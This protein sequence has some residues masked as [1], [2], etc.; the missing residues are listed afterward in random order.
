M[1]DITRRPDPRRLHL[2]VHEAAHAVVGV[3]HGARLL[4]ATLASDGNAGH[5]QFTAASFTNGGPQVYRSH[6]AA[7]GAV[8]EAMLTHG[9]R[10]TLRQIEARLCGSDKED[11]H[12]QAMATLLPVP[13]PA[14]EVTSLLA[15]CW[16]AVADLAADLYLGTAITHAQVCAGLGLTD[17]GGPGSTQLATIRNGWAPPSLR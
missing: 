5:T 6:I 4:R 7:A 15:R 14:A 1:T 3:I 9:P 16:P 12:R 17:E 11:L 8:A 10:P 13:V 2:A